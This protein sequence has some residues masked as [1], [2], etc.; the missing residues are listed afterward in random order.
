MTFPASVHRFLAPLL[1]VVLAGCVPVSVPE[2][3]FFYPEARLR[4]EN[5]VLP[6]SQ[7]WPGAE[8][9][10]IPYPGGAVAATRI[11]TGEA[12]TPL[13]LFCGGNMFRRRV[14]TFSAARKLTPFGDVLMFDYPGYGD[15]PGQADVAGFRAAGEAVAATARAQ[16]DA[17]GRPLIAWGHSLGGPICAGIAQETRADALVLEATTPSAR[18]AVNQ[19]AGMMRPFLRFDI[20]PGL[21]AINIPASLE[22]YAGRVVVL[23]AGK[24]TTLPPALSRALARDLTAQGVEVQRLVFPAAGHNDIGRQPDFQPRLAAALALPDRT[25]E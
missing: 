12:R 18:A 11:R 15:T 25:A 17:E 2:N 3:A 19:Q 14:N 16:A 1:A 24:D 7:P 9:L 21:A 4:A 20:A 5:I 10:A 8:T 22:G 13:I 23:E 6:D